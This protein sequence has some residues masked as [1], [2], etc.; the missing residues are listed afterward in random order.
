MNTRSKERGHFVGLDT[1]TTKNKDKDNERRQNVDVPVSVPVSVGVEKTVSE[2]PV[3]V[4]VEVTVEDDT[5]KV[6]PTPV[7]I[8]DRIFWN[9]CQSSIFGFLEVLEDSVLEQS[10]FFGRNIPIVSS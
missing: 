9:F 3:S 10:V 4:P 6:R 2:E 1:A 8:I 7:V 5:I